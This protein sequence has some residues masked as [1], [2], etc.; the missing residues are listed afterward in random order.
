[1]KYPPAPNPKKAFLLNSSR[2]NPA[3][4]LF[5]S[6]TKRL[7]VR[8]CQNA[9]PARKTVEGLVPAVGPHRGDI[10]QKVVEAVLTIFQLY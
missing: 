6:V 9:E 10:F 1:V 7:F 5:N 2:R 8:R 4:Y 3:I